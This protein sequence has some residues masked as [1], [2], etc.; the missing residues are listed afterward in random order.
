VTAAWQGFYDG[1]R[2]IGGIVGRST[3]RFRQRSAA[4]L[5]AMYLITGAAWASGRVSDSVV[6]LLRGKGEPVRVKV[7]DND[8]AGVG[9]ANS[10]PR[11]WSPISAVRSS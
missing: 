10:G 8:P 2:P 6:E 4:K 9:F 5:T 3:V 1:D 11:S 7:P